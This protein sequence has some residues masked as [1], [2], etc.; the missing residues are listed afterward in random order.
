M[1]IDEWNPTRPGLARRLRATAVL[2]GL[3]FALPAA[4]AAEEFQV[5]GLA[6]WRLGG[7]GS[8]PISRQNLDIGGAGSL[9]GAA[10]FELWEQGSIE[11][12]FSRAEATARPLFG[13]EEPR[14]AI[15]YLLLGVVY[16]FQTRGLRPFAGLSLGGAR[17]R[18]TPGGEKTVFSGSA[19]AGIRLFP[20]RHVGLRAEGRLLFVADEDDRIPRDSRGGDDLGARGDAIFQGELAIGLVLAF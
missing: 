11:L 15:S 9:G 3:L 16:E 4:G 5:A 19:V 8:S 1:H 20:T 14:V 17:F 18:E 10:S 12:Y 7:S 13:N 6:G 2:L